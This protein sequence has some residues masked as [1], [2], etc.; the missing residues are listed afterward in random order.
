MRDYMSNVELA[1][2]ILRR[3]EKGFADS[4]YVDMPSAT[5]ASEDMMMRA[6]E[7]AEELYEGERHNNDIISLTR[8]LMSVDVEKYHV[9]SKVLNKIADFVERNQE[10]ALSE[11][12]IEYKAKKSELFKKIDDYKKL[13][14][15]TFSEEF[16]YERAKI[17]LYKDI[18]DF[19]NKLDFL[20]EIIFIIETYHI[21]DFEEKSRKK[22]NMATE[23]FD[24]SF[25]NTLANEGGYGVQ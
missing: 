23:D 6:K 15:D 9:N 21:D 19:Q 3:M 8:R 18:Q 5:S 22:H 14:E 10:T 20:E 25:I 13:R 1:K 16:D 24:F 12:K 7:G 4:P 2:S 11:L 17:H